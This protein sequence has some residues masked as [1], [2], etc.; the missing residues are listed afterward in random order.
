MPAETAELT[1]AQSVLVLVSE[2]VLELAAGGA[3]VLLPAPTANV[4]V[5]EFVLA[6]VPAVVFVAAA[7]GV[8]LSVQLILFAR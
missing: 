4:A 1:G 2:G 6:A 8:L 3:L 7:A 5:A